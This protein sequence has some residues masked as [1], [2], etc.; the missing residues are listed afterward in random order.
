MPGTSA[1]SYHASTRACASRRAFPKGRTCSGS[2][3]PPRESC[4]S[5]AAASPL[6][7]PAR[8]TSCAG[9]WPGALESEPVRGLLE[10]VPPFERRTLRFYGL[11]ESTLAAALEQAGGEGERRHGHDLRPRARAR[12]SSSSSSPAPRL[13]PTSS[14]T[15]CIA[16]GP[17]TLFARDERPIEE[18]VLELARARA[19]TLATAESCTGGLV[20]G[21]LTSVPG[22][23]DVFRGSIVAYSNE[24]KR[25]A[26]GV[27]EETLAQHGAVSAEC[28][29]ELAQGARR[30][31]GAD[32][33]VTVTGI[34]GP[35]GGTRR[36][37]GRAGL[38]LRRR[39]RRADRA[40]APFRG[41]GIRSA[42]TRRSR[43][44]TCSGGF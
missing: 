1:P 5:T 28:A 24:I 34:A 4:S 17:D 15:R 35:S 10:R 8:R 37:A 13:A 40:G 23:S 12:L 20:A 30:V 27:A 39:T 32:V 26:L 14:R 18:I 11:S 36:E 21:R 42:A 22:A 29:L 33:A 3:A 19:L 44:F 2:P 38:P 25:T 7:C 9:L 31:L 16:A 6:S 41:G 43:R